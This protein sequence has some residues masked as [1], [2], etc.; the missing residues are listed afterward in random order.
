MDSQV[1]AEADRKKRY[2]GNEKIVNS[3]FEYFALHRE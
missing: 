2:R 1:G 3:G